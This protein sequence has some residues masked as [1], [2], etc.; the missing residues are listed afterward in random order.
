MSDDTINVTPR[1]L[2]KLLAR[3]ARALETQSGA[4]SDAELDKLAARFVNEL[5]PS[6]K[7]TASTPNRMLNSNVAIKFR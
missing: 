2:Q 4:A 6:C 1:Q 5:S 3:F 7:V